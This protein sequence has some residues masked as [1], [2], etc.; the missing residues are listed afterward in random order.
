MNSGM[1]RNRLTS[2]LG[3]NSVNKAWLNIRCLEAKRNVRKS[4]K[5]LKKECHCNNSRAAVIS[6]KKV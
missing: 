2:G 4:C 6:S 3:K 5:Q 1:M